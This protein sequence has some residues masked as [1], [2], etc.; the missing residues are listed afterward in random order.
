MNNLHSKD[1]FYLFIF[2]ISL[3]YYLCY[4]IYFFLTFAFHSISYH[5]ALMVAFS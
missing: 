1:L 4:V 3:I 5:L 2:F